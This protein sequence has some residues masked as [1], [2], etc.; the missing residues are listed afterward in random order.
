MKYPFAYGTMQG[1]FESARWGFT[2]IQKIIN[3]KFAEVEK[4]LAAH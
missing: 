3:E 4:D 2:P 1:L